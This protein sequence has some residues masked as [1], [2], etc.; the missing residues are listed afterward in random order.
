MKEDTA[1]L[2]QTDTKQRILDTAEH[3]FA[4]E[5]YHSTSLRAITGQANVNL[6]AVNYHFGSKEAL[7]EA[8]IERRI[9]PLHKIRKQN[10]EAVQ[11]AA[12]HEGRRPLVKEALRAFIEPTIAFRESGEVADDFSMLIG[13]AIIDPDDTVRKI[14]L[15]HIEPIFH[16]LFE[17]LRQALPDFSQDILFWR[18]HFAIGAMAHTLHMR[19][20]EESAHKAGKFR[21][22]P[23][24][25]S[26]YNAS[27]MTDMLIA[28][29]S[30][31]MEA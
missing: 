4:R 7:I 29:V 25:I 27:S 13:R 31:G 5:G 26:A 21:C 10:L 28:F 6:A 12:R 30:A 2:N 3:L 20:M 18:L 11:E 23:E 19:T 8:V 1:V 24:G 15:Q 22:L 14:F 17:T 9:V 16:L